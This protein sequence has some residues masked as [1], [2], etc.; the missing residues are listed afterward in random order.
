M[1]L[2]KE[3]S[4]SK[5]ASV[6]GNFHKKEKN[7]SALGPSPKVFG[8]LEIL[9]ENI[10]M[11]SFYSV[12]KVRENKKEFPFQTFKLS[13]KSRSKNIQNAVASTVK[14]ISIKVHTDKH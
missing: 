6:P 2:N 14:S 7:Y 3:N 1:F 5:G 9:R 8:N 4:K 13:V 10:L 11:L 12:P